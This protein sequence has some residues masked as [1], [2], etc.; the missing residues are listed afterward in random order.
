M[1]TASGTMKPFSEE[2]ILTFSTSSLPN[3][4]V[5]PREILLGLFDF[6]GGNARSIM[7][8]V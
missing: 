2:E 8:V 1:P 4:H 7:N 6:F 5:I 3:T